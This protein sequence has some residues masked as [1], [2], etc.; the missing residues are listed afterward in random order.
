MYQLWLKHV[1][2]SSYHFLRSPFCD[3]LQHVGDCPITTVVCEFHRCGS[4]YFMVF[5][6]SSV[7]DKWTTCFTAIN[8]YS[9]RSHLHDMPSLISNLTTGFATYLQRRW[10]MIE[11]RRCSITEQ[12]EHHLH[13]CYQPSPDYRRDTYDIDIPSPRQ[14]VLKHGSQVN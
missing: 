5:L 7:L 9:H 8:H 11:W 12:H 4:G 13:H 2:L 6:H 3:P 1:I 10:V 14:H